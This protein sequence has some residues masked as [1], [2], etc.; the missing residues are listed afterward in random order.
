MGHGIGIHISIT[1]HYNQHL[2]SVLKIISYHDFF[3]I[4]PF[5]REKHLYA[6][7]SAYKSLWP[8]WVSLFQGA[9]F[10]HH[11]M[12]VLQLQLPQGVI[13]EGTG[14]RCSKRSGQASALAWLRPQKPDDAPC[15]QCIAGISWQTVN[16]P[17]Q[18]LKGCWHHCSPT[19]S[20]MPLSS[21]GRNQLKCALWRALR[22]SGCGAL[23]FIFLYLSFHWIENT[24]NLNS[25]LCPVGRGMYNHLNTC[26]T[27]L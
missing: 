4:C 22:P 21:S 19:C 6:Q 7:W 1:F 26:Y 12:Q 17:I 25:L 18:A 11:S 20:L 13:T 15:V 9:F 8:V 14:C 10:I 5:M 24:F 3:F 2:P 27:A 16:I 23:E